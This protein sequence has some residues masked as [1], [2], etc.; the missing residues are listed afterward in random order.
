MKHAPRGITMA[1]VA[2]ALAF[3]IVFAFAVP[4]GRAFS[5]HRRLRD[6]DWIASASPAQLRET[7][8]RALQFRFSDPHDAFVVLQTHGDSSSIGALR[9][10]LRRQ[11]VD[12]TGAIECTWTHGHAAL[13]RALKLPP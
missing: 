13:E 4:Q 9:A 10:A 6:L 11:P 8:H 3:A 7:A 2:A 12:P 1:A 5:A